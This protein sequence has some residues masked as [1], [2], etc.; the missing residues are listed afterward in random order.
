MPLVA[1]EPRSQANRRELGLLLRLAAPIAAAQGGQAL[2]SLVDVAVVG[3]VSKTQLAAV[4]LANSIFFAVSVVGIGLMMGLDP[5][6]SQALGAGDRVR[7]RQLLWQGLWLAV[8]TSAL[9]ELPML[10]G[11]AILHVMSVPPETAAV[12]MR[13]VEIRMIGLPPMLLFISMRSYLQATGVTR[14]LVW[15][16]VAG[17]IFNFDADVTL[18]FGSGRIPAMG[19]PGSAIATT[20]GLFLQLGILALAVRSMETSSCRRARAACG[21]RI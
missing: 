14:P 1:V 11:P 4:G 10:L 2:M 12:A 16:V 19:G 8:F 9:L 3:R 15:S 20:L 17:N 6:A 5:L 21:G 7:A 13:C 18:V